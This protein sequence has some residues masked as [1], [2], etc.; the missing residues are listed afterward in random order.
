MFGAATESIRPEC[1]SRKVSDTRNFLIFCT[2]PLKA[3][4]QLP[5]F[6]N[7]LQR[8]DTHI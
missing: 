8:M 1:C 3:G 4:F 2:W 5:F 7:N 6:R